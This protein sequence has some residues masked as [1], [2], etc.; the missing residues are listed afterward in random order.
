MYEINHS[1]GY[2]KIRH[3]DAPCDTAGAQGKVN[4]TSIQGDGSTFTYA[5]RYL[6]LLTFNVATSEDTDGNS[7]VKVQNELE[8]ISIEQAAAIMSAAKKVGLDEATICSKCRIG[9]LRELG[10]AR[11]TAVM[12]DLARRLKAKEAEQ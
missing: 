2:S 6:T 12:N 7:P 4:K 10:A 5:R 9:H 1:G 8:T 3:Y 11:Y